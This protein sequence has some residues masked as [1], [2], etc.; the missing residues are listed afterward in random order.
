MGEGGKKGFAQFAAEQKFLGVE[1]D[2]TQRWNSGFKKVARSPESSRRAQEIVS[3]TRPPSVPLEPVPKRIGRG[4]VFEGPPARGRSDYAKDRAGRMRTEGGGEKSA[5]SASMSSKLGGVEDPDHSRRRKRRTRDGDP[6]RRHRS[7]K[8]RTRRRE[9]PRTPTPPSYYSEYSLSEGHEAEAPTPGEETAREEKKEPFHPSSFA[10]GISVGSFAKAAVVPEGLREAAFVTPQIEAEPR[11]SFAKAAESPVF[12]EVEIEPRKELGRVKP[13][14]GGAAQ[15]GAE[16]EEK[17]MADFDMRCLSIYTSFMD[18]NVEMEITEILSHLTRGQEWTEAFS[19]LTRPKR[20]ATGLRY[21]RLL[22]NYLQW[23]KKETE[24]HPHPV[25]PI[26][27][28]VVWLYLH[29]LVKDSVGAYT[30]KSFLLAFRFLGEAFG[31]SLEACGYQ[32]NKKLIESHSRTLKPK[33]KAPMIPVKTMEFLECCVEDPS[34]PVGYRIAAGKLRLCIQASMRWDDLSRTPVG[35]LE[36]VRHFGCAEIV[37]LRSKDA[38]SKTGVRPWV[39]S[40]LSVVKE[41]DDWLPVLMRL[42]IASHGVEWKI[43]DHF[44]KTF[45]ADGRVAKDGVASFSQD[46][47]FVRYLLC[48]ALEKGVDLELDEEGVKLLRWHGAKSTLTSVMMHLNEGDRAVRFSGN[49]K[50]QKEAMPD[51]YLREAQLLVLRAQEKALAFIRSGGIIGRL[52]GVPLNPGPD[53]FE[54]DEAAADF[55][56]TKDRVRKTIGEFKPPSGLGIQDVPSAVLDEI[57]RHGEI[58]G[59]ILAAEKKSENFDIENISDLVVSAADSLKESPS[60]AVADEDDSD[61]DSVVEFYEELFVQVKGS[62]RASLHKIA[63]TE[64]I[65]PRCNVSGSGFEVVKAQDPVSKGTKF[66]QRCFGKVPSNGC[67]KLCTKTRTVERDGVQV[68]VRCGRRCHLGCKPVARYL[69][70]DDREH[71]CDVHAEV[72]EQDI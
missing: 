26:D 23:V 69:D 5:P 34:L 18:M 45:S 66:C 29:T 47:S 65:K 8:R 16:K 1:Q 30:P 35:H 50:D 59:E 33:N 19:C 55:R 28:E 17:L 15:S 67:N 71:R 62:L 61:S 58:S 25:D 20:A 7:R 31:F 72:I 6:L 39:A 68:T 41:G 3:P 42:V 48:G 56:E 51:C 4:E 49:W 21:I 70:L 53:H 27:K 54:T 40:Y 22:E 38:T 13:L 64:E 37:G 36:W 24:P 12:P 9:R 10:P 57:A 43:H 32:R 14:G 60:P 63:T 2:N 52:E 46:V 11:R 44:G